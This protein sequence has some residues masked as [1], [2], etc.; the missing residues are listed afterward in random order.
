M[1]FLLAEPGE[2]SALVLFSDDFAN[3]G[4]WHSVFG[5]WTAS[6]GLIQGANPS[7]G[8]LGWTGDT[9]WTNYQVTANLRI[10]SP[11]DEAV[12]VLRYTHWDTYY[13][14]GLGPSNH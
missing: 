13:W 4:N 9:A 1:S 10:L 3:L 5:T 6:N 12:L 14:M 7:G 2:V 11:G 8:V